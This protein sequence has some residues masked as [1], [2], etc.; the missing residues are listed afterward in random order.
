MLPNDH[1]MA[2]AALSDRVAQRNTADVKDGEVIVATYYDDKGHPISITQKE[3][4]A[5]EMWLLSMNGLLAPQSS[6]RSGSD[7]RSTLRFGPSRFSR[8]FGHSSSSVCGDASMRHE[9]EHDVEAGEETPLH[10]VP[11]DS[12]GNLVT[13]GGE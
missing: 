10:I 12:E 11:V 7:D 5:A 4:Q 6:R 9:P 2:S 8:D 13:R 3:R 1:E